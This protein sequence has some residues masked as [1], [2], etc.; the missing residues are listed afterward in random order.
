M[1]VSRNHDAPHQ[2]LTLSEIARLRLRSLCSSL[3][4]PNVE[5]AEAA[6]SLLTQT[7]RNE[8]LGE[9][10]SWSTDLT[11]DGSPFEFSVAFDEAVELRMLAEPQFAPFDLASNWRAAE[12]TNASLALLTGVSMRRLDRIAPLFAPRADSRASFAMWHAVSMKSGAPPAFKVYLNPQIHGAAR[13]PTLVNE[14]LEALGMTNALKFIGERLARPNERFVYFSLDLNDAATARVKVYVAFDSTDPSELEKLFVGTKHYQTGSVDKWMTALMGESPT[15]IDSVRAVLGCAAFSDGPMPQVTLHVPIRRHAADDE[16]ALDR[17]KELVDA[18][19]AARLERTVRSWAMRPLDA[20]R[21]LMT[22]ASCRNEAKGTRLTVYLAPQLFAIAA[23]RTLTPP[24]PVYSHIRELNS[25]TQSNA[26]TRTMHAVQERIQTHRSVLA[27]H[28]FIRHLDTDGTYDAIRSVAR[29]LTFFVLAFQ[30]MLRLARVHAG[31][32][33]LAELART[34]EAEDRGHEQ[35]FLSDLVILDLEVDVRWLFSAAH[36]STRDVSYAI[37][38][39]VLHATDD[40][41]R[42]AVLLSLEAAGAEFFGRV[43]SYLER[44]GRSENLQYFARPHQHVEQNHSV[45]EQEEQR[46]LWSTPLPEDV[47]DE[48]IRSV[49]HTFENMT[50][51]ATNL[52]AAMLR[53]DP[54]QVAS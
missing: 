39:D 12:E 25:S 53:A 42:L 43:I 26:N 32:G 54:A 2:R 37:M 3:D 6:L 11:D 16:Q 17:A 14:A 27:R 1:N 41:S 5:A 52:D 8:P 9:G 23:P 35:W 50:R 49:D 4:W 21:G 24:T 47:Y 15:P 36:A 18:R 28:S 38:S 7:F 45:F 33:P 19:T 48:V 34:H 13:A 46:R 30:D 10:P 29:Q 20:G 51:L 22:Y 44:L 40:R 31:E